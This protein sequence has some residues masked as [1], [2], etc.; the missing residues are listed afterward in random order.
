MQANLD[1][2]G[3]QNANKNYIQVFVHPM[4][5]QKHYLSSMHGSTNGWCNEF[6]SQYNLLT[7]TFIATFSCGWFPFLLNKA[8]AAFFTLD[9]TCLMLAA[10]S[11]LWFTWPLNTGICM[12]ITHAYTSNRDIL[13]WIEILQTR[14]E[15]EKVSCASGLLA[16]IQLFFWYMCIGKACI[17]ANGGPPGWSLSQFLQHETTW[18]ISTPPWMGC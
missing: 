16:S 10:T 5:F 9:T 6:L 11:E 4:Q 13:D 14:Q 2:Q 1:R 12:T 18:S 17:W 3:K 7:F 15:F 8:W